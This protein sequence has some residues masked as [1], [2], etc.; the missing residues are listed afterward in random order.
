MTKCT[1]YWYYKLSIYDITHLTISIFIWSKSSVTFTYE[2]KID[3]VT[4]FIGIAVIY[5]DT[6]QNQILQT[7]QCKS[8][9]PMN[10][11]R[12]YWF[13][14]STILT[15]TYQFY[16]LHLHLQKNQYHIRTKGYQCCRLHW[17]CS[18]LHQYILNGD[19]TNL[20]M[21]WKK[22]KQKRD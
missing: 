14:G 10:R 22:D 20:Q 9:R 11:T 7:I 3:S 6:C 17:Y 19:N 18:H 2:I 16:N 4:H 13:S 8:L 21:G 1:G 15:A 5:I 12:N